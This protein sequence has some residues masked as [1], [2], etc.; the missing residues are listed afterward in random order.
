MKIA[1]VQVR[2]V[3]RTN[4]RVKDTL[5]ML[6]LPKKNSCVLVDAN[7]SYKGM[8][9]FIKDF[10]TWGEIDESVVLE[11]IQKRGKIVGSKP[12]T[13]QYVKEKTGMALPAFVKEFYNG[14]KKLKDVPG[15]K[16]YFRLKP[17][18]KG[19][20]RGGVKVPFSM[21]GALGYR[22]EYINDLVK[23]ML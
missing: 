8:I 10:V 18:T 20:E 15:M 4:Q 22:K 23:R 14:T 12:L 16:P 9:E 2:G 5:R 3:I 21:G 17:P 11:L 1:I 19:Y 7:P 13:E 6:K